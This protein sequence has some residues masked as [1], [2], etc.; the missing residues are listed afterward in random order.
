MKVYIAAPFGDLKFAALIAKGLKQTADIDCTSRWLTAESDLSDTWARN[1]LADIDSADVFVALNA[2]AWN[3]PEAQKGSGGRHVELGYALAKGKPI[4]LVGV[5]SNIFHFHSDVR[6]VSWH[7]A[8]NLP[9]VLA[10]ALE[11]VA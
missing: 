9:A 5:R 10:D 2:E 11:Q 4:V 8:L 3:R 1:D 6:L 7:D